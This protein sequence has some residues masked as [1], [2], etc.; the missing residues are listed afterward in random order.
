MV[1]FLTSMSKQLP[2]HTS[3][4]VL[5]LL[6]GIVILYVLNNSGSLNHVLNDG[7]LEHA[8]ESTE[9]LEQVEHVENGN[10][11]NNQYN[12]EVNNN[13]DNS[14]YPKFPKD[15][16]TPDELLPKD[17]NSLWAEVH[18]TGEGELKDKNFLQ[19]GYHVGVDTVGQSLRNANLQLRS[20][21]PNPRKQVSPW[22]Q[23]TV[24]PDTNRAP[25]EIGS[26]NYYDTQ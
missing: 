16:L 10:G 19:S 15:Q 18:P 3:K 14:N 4:I 23:S 17:N 7:N 12:V 6:L 9:Q 22:Q 11:I 1:N 20:E 25:F 24:E 26:A 5:A 2:K 8:T 13:G 21:P